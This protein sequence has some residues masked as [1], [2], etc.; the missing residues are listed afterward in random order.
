MVL[1]RVLAIQHHES[2]GYTSRHPQMK[3]RPHCGLT[4]TSVPN[5]D[6]GVDKMFLLVTRAL[7]STSNPKEKDEFHT[8]YAYPD[9]RLISLPKVAVVVTLVRTTGPRL[10][11]CRGSNG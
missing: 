11:S 9:L 4:T 6:G 8:D 5:T 7:T 2:L 1:T 10:F 3:K